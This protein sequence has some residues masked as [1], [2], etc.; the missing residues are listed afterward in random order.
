MSIYSGFQ[1]LKNSYLLNRA[2]EFK[3][4]FTIGILA[5][6][7]LKLD[8]A[9]VCFDEIFLMPTLTLYCTTLLLHGATL[10]PDCATFLK[11]KFAAT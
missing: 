5:T 3:S 1:I 4:I 8:P 7:S 2:S 9:W 11:T 6:R 10:V